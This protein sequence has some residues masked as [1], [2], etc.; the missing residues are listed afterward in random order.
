MCFYIYSE[1]GEISLDHIQETIFIQGR[2]ESTIVLVD[3]L[4][5][6]ISPK[7]I[8][9]ACLIYPNIL[10]KIPEE[11][12][13]ET[14]PKGVDL[15]GKHIIEKTNE[16]ADKKFTKKLYDAAGRHFTISGRSATLKEPDPED[17]TQN[18]VFKGDIKKNRNT[19]SSNFILA[20]QSPP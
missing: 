3:F 6:N 15:L 8:K 12:E 5:T 4:I 17:I 7:T 11:I 20:L 13:F 14:P 10:F 19:S 16:L 2:E 18:L 1:E 9:S